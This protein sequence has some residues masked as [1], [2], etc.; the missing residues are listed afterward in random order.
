MILDTDSA[1]RAHDG[2]EGA[3]ADEINR[4]FIPPG[5]T[6][7][8]QPLDRRVVG[9]VKSF[10]RQLWR[11]RYH[12]TEGAKTARSIIAQ[13]LVDSWE[14]ITPEI[15]DSGWNSYWAWDGGDDGP[16]EDDQRD[17]TYRPVFRLDDVE[18]A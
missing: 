7:R 10:A 14:R 2:R 18:E 8:L 6:D 17:E 3:Q 4:V 5:G 11:R 15:I 1:H 12:E 13:N 16:E 9:V